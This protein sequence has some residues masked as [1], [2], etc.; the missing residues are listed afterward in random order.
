MCGARTSLSFAHCV[1]QCRLLTYASV[2]RALPTYT[3][4]SGV[5]DPMLRYLPRVRR[6]QVV[7]PVKLMELNCG[8]IFR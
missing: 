8:M 6:G 5:N 1:I 2:Q 4:S 3:W 7:Q